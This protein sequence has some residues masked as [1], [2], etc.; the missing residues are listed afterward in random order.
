[1]ALGVFMPYG[2]PSWKRFKNFAE[3]VYSCEG[4]RGVEALRQL[5]VLSYVNVPQ[6][7]KILV[8]RALGL[9]LRAH[10]GQLRKGDSLG[11]RRP[12]FHHIAM[13]WFMVVI[14]GGSFEQ[15]IAAILHDVIEDG[16]ERLNMTRSEIK[17]YIRATFG[18]AIYNIVISLTNPE[19]LSTE[20]K[21]VWQRDHFMQMPL[22]EQVNKMCDK[23]ANWYDSLHDAPS[24]WGVDKF[25]AD[26]E[27]TR[28]MFEA[29]DEVSAICNVYGSLLQIH[30]KQVGV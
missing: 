23:L 7:Q 13:V 8:H 24:S 21:P 3:F 19:G 30:A 1:M 22:H 11:Y 2:N 4:D 26:Y 20:E 17:M 15:Q 9:A 18:E 6:C 29:M 5:I 25:K 14:S 12:Y 27:L 16:G 10:N 28:D